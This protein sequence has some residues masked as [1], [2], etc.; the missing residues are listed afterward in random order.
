MEASLCYKQKLIDCFFCEGCKEEIDFLQQSL[1]EEELNVQKI[2]IDSE[3]LNL[4]DKDYKILKAIQHL[5]I[6]KLEISKYTQSL[7]TSILKF[8]KESIEKIVEISNKYHKI[9]EKNGFLSFRLRENTI[10]LVSKKTHDAYY[11]QNDKEMKINFP[12]KINI[13]NPE[14]LQ[15]EK[16]NLEDGEWKKIRNEWNKIETEYKSIRLKQIELDQKIKVIEFE[17]KKIEEE[18]KNI[19][20]KEMKFELSRKEFREI[21]DK[22]QQHRKKKQQTKPEPRIFTENIKLEKG[23]K[24]MQAFLDKSIS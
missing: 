22:G 7:I 19:E 11:E 15:P 9:L 12:I 20:L 18:R 24:K 17:Q 2:S 16:L 4:K 5:S 3:N 1:Y 23:K 8:R 14:I 21:N 13:E 6:T 10:K